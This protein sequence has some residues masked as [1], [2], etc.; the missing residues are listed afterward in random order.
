MKVGYILLQEDSHQREV[1]SQNPG[2]KTA[3]RAEEE[4]EMIYLNTS[5]M[6]NRPVKQVFDFVSKPE[7]DFQW[8]YG[9]LAAA[10]LSADDATVLGTFFRSIG[11]LMGHRVQS[12][13]EVTEYEPNRKYGFKSLSGPFQSRTSYTFEKGRDFTQ[14]ALST[15]VYAINF[16]QVDQGVLKEKMKKQLGE[17]LA[18]LKD[19]L[20]A[21]RTL[22]AS[23]IVLL[24]E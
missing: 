1:G 15:Q 13:F 10:R 14:I 17:D 16:F 20:E 2:L 7:N 19:L 5:T 21:K 6:I 11:H 23:E 18:M 24:A 9:T 3:C 12:T 22:P 4:S 8:H